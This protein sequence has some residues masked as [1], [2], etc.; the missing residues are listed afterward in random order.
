MLKQRHGLAPPTKNI[1]NIRFKR[2]PNEDPNEVHA[3]EKILK[4]I[5]DV[6]KFADLL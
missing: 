6:S 1:R 3:V 4:D 2:E 5:I